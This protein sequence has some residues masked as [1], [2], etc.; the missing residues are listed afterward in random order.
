MI[1][2]AYIHGEESVVFSESIGV[3]LDSEGSIVCSLR[4]ALT[5]FYIC[6]A[7]VTVVGLYVYV[8]VSVCLLLNISLL[9]DYSCHKR[10]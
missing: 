8:C 2:E 3:E 5:M 6:A 1:D 7:R 10:Y 9:P 4:L